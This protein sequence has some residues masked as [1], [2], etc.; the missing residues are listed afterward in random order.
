MDDVTDPRQ[1]TSPGAWAARLSEVWDVGVVVLDPS[2]APDFAN[3][4]AMALLDVQ[5]EAALASRWKAIEEALAD[6]LRQASPSSLQ[7]AEAMLKVN[8]VRLRVQIYTV[9]E[10]NCVGHLLLVQH[11]DRAELLETSLLHASHDRGLASL[12]RD[13]AHD[14]KTVMNVIGLN[15]TMLSKA[16][17]IEEPSPEQVVTAAKSAD[18][19]RR[20]LRRLD[21][22]VT[23]VLD[24]TRLGDESAEAFDLRETYRHVHELARGRAT[25]QGVDIR[26]RVPE[27]PVIFV[28]YPDRL[29]AAVLNLVVNALDAMPGGG[30]IDLGLEGD[31]GQ[32]IVLTVR[33]TG[34]GLGPEDLPNLW[35]AHY[36]TKPT[37]TGIGLHV[38]KATVEAHGGRITYEHNPD[39]PSGAMF[40]IELPAATAVTP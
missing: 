18:T 17:G 16:T 30:T 15:L 27:T 36:T 39:A 19:I 20:E 3:S 34:P 11:A 2:G 31:D 33:D 6:T 22:F 12:Y 38:T 23:L 4:R 29:Q 9:E 14:L 35:R 5:N 13:I 40:R 25:R 10:E 1:R 21:R 8:D 37:G 28:G 24:R 32:S 26:V 7:P